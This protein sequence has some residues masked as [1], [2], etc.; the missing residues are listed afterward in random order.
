MPV[1]C[2]FVRWRYPGGFRPLLEEGRDRA[3]PDQLR[4]AT[5]QTCR[6]IPPSG[7]RPE[8]RSMT[9]DRLSARGGTEVGRRQSHGCLEGKRKYFPLTAI[10]LSELDANAALC[11]VDAAQLRQGNPAVCADVADLSEY[12]AEWRVPRRMRRRA[13]PYRDIPAVGLEVQSCKLPRTHVRASQFLCELRQIRCS[14]HSSP[15]R[16]TDESVDLSQTSDKCSYDTRLFCGSWNALPFHSQLRTAR[17]MRVVRERADMLHLL[18][19]LQPQAR[20]SKVTSG[21]TGAVIR[22]SRDVWNFQ[23]NS[24]DSAARH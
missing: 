24:E 13:D 6:S 3:L 9:V 2:L 16:P 8:C 15:P 17:L 5:E 14:V 1:Q 21:R 23:L 10:A 4:V 11:E 18:V 7:A 12:Q 19:V 22:R 20:H